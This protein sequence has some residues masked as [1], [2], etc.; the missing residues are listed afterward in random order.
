MTAQHTPGPWSVEPDIRTDLDR[1]TKEEREYVAGYNIASK[2][3]EIVGAEGII[4]GG[5]AEANARLIAEAPAMLDALRE[6]TDVFALDGENSLDRFER[7]ASMFHRDT[8]YIAPGKDQPACGP[9]GAEPEELRA[10][11]DAWYAAK[12]T[13]ARAI[14]AR[15]DGEPS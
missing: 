11:Y 9:V 1:Y 12:V 14:L 8:G 3:G 10:I 4:P 5:A 13:R 2:D 6:L 15:I 7:L